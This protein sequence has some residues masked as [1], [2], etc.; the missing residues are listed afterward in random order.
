MF[1]IEDN[2]QQRRKVLGRQ[3][4]YSTEQRKKTL[5]REE[6]CSAQN[7]NAQEKRKVFRREENSSAEQQCAHQ[8]SIVLVGHRAT[9]CQMRRF[10]FIYMYLIHL[11]QANHSCNNNIKEIFDIYF[12]W[13]RRTQRQICLYKVF[14]KQKKK[15]NTFNK[16]PI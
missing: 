2:A 8:R 13:E 4:K 6:K 11:F 10:N 12:S 15:Q 5:G 9:S 16:I 14:P 7:I 1:S 3:E